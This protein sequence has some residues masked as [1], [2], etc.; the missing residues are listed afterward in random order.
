MLFNPLLLIH[1]NRYSQLRG[2]K[3]SDYKLA[4]LV[5]SENQFFNLANRNKNKDLNGLFIECLASCHGITRVNGQII[6]DPIDVKMFEASGWELNENL[7][8]QDNYD[9]LVNKICLIFF[10]K[11]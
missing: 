11:I 8:N 9:S 6:G 3:Q 10:K 7:E 5:N 1:A 2:K 4:K